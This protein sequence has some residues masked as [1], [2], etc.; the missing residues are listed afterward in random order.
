MPTK[1]PRVD[2]YIGG[3]ADFA[4][5]VLTHIRKLVHTACAD[6]VETIKW[7]MPHF[8]YRGVLCGM[9]AFKRHCA[10]GFWKRKQIFPQARGSARGDEAMGQ[11]G[12]ITTISDLPANKV[13]IGYI[14]RAVELNEAGVKAPEKPKSD[15]KKLVIPR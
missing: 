13:L 9:A 2:A 3:A 12:R 6:V 14:T 1:D 8:E 15:T 11:F 5:P 10:L 7:G 4:K